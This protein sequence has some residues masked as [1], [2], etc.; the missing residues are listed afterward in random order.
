METNTQSS[1]GIY[2]ELKR[3]DF[4]VVLLLC[5]L[6]GPLK[7]GCRNA[8]TNCTERNEN[9]YGRPDRLCFVPP[10]PAADPLPL[11]PYRHPPETPS[12]QNDTDQ[13]DKHNISQSDLDVGPA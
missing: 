2:D 12:G 13:E 6:T 10:T 7:K 9:S 5:R 11:T 4:D 3:F 1:I 8:K